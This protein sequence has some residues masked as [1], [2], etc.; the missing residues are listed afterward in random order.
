MQEHSVKVN[1][2]GAVTVTVD[3]AAENVVGLGQ[4]VVHVV[5]S[6][7]SVDKLL[8]AEAVTN[9]LWPD[10]VVRTLVW[11]L[12]CATLESTDRFDL[13]A[14]L[15]TAEDCATERASL[16]D[17]LVVGLMPLLAY[18]LPEDA[19]LVVDKFLPEEEVGATATDR[20]LDEAA[21]DE[22]A[23]GAELVALTLQP[24]ES[25]PISS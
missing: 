24:T 4:Y 5:A 22:I 16:L 13:A 15:E 8:E 23:A 11:E 1:V 21:L 12:T 3:P 18:S 6:A 20:G 19:M 17:G 14:V 7:K 10:P 25:C 9:D 2:V